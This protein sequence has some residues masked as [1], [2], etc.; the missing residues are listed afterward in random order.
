MQ[1]LVE[2]KVKMLVKKKKW[3]KNVKFWENAKLLQEFKVSQIEIKENAM[4]H[5][6]TYYFCEK[7]QMV[8]ERTNL[9]QGKTF[10]RERQVFWRTNIFMREH[11]NIS[12]KNAILLE[13]Y[14]YIVSLENVTLLEGV[15]ENA[16]FHR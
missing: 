7:M 15:R 8:C 12:W 1:G 13:L 9:G 5:G 14:I 16:K 4:F 6:R 11:N 2:L 10:V 3:Q